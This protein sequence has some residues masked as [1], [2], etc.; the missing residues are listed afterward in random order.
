MPAQ[1]ACEELLA[2]RE[3]LLFGPV[4]VPGTE[5]RLEWTLD[6]EG[7]HALVVGVGV[8]VE[9]PVLGLFEDEGE[10]IEDEVGPEPDVLRALRLDGRAEIAQPPHEAVRAVRTDDEIGLPQRFHLRPEDELDA[11]RQ[12]SRLQDLQ[13]PSPRDRRERVAP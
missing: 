2:E 12:A 13:Q 5:P 9:E 3:A 6:D 1:V 8:N 4:P 7:A 11:E 10:R